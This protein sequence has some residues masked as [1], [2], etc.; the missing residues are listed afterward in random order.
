MTY[1]ATYAATYSYIYIPIP[2]FLLINTLCYL[3]TFL[4][5]LC[6]TIYSYT[7]VYLTT[8]FSTLLCFLQLK[9]VHVF[10]N[11]LVTFNYLLD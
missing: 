8:L 6:I 1:W 11:I 10:I 3:A 4:K 7:C 2:V 9:N 5:S